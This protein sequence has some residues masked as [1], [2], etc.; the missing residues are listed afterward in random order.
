MT[1][2]AMIRKSMDL[3]LY[4]RNIRHKRVNELDYIISQ[5]FD[6]NEININNRCKRAMI[7]IKLK[8]KKLIA[9]VTKKK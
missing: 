6:F 2:I 7:W 8:R 4:D 1:D 9:K 3:F 5:K